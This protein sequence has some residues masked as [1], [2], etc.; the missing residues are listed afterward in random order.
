[1]D[2]FSSFVVK[3]SLLCISIKAVIYFGDKPVIGLCLSLHILIPFSVLFL[4]S[5]ILYHTL[6]Y[7][8]IFL[9]CIAMFTGCFELWKEQIE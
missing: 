8:C 9:Y 3:S 4:S 6:Y 2:F 7:C 5:V 1:M